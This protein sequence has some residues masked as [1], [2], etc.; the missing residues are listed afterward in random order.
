M[1]ELFDALAK[2]ASSKLSRRQ[3]F[4]RFAAGLVT[5]LIAA[6]GLA[7]ADN[8]CGKLCA[9]CCRNLDFPPRSPEHGKCVSDCHNGLGPCGPLV[10]PQGH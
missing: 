4:G 5:S 1:D 3:V 10:C 6:L 9:E 7:R 2:D 8:P